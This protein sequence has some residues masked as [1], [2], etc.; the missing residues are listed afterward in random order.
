MVS[1]PDRLEQFKQKFNYKPELNGYIG[2]EREFF[3]A[4]EAGLLVPEAVA[5][6][7][8]LKNPLSGAGTFSY[9][10]SACQIEFQSIPCKDEKSIAETQVQLEGE[11]HRAAKKLGLQVLCLEVAS[12]DMP[13]D[14]FPDPEGRYQVI[15]DSMTRDVRLAA[16]RICATH[17]HVGMPDAETAL[18]TYNKVIKHSQRLSQIGDKSAGERIKLYKIV[19]PNS[20]PLAHESWE[21]FHHYAIKNGFEDNPRNCW[22]MIRLTI[23][24]TIE[25]RNFGVTKSIEEISQWASL[26]RSL[27]L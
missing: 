18:K 6:L 26:C 1:L 15:A 4:N 11:L 2:I 19:A 22:T 3:I 8:E 24:G 5:L 17:F 9:E 21:S 20:Q 10:L 23:H 12:E 25:F 16:S 27:C 7:G 14:V 13:L